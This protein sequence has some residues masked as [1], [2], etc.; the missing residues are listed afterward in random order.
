MK[1]INIV[2]SKKRICRLRA[3]FVRIVT[4]R[5]RDCGKACRDNYGEVTTARLIGPIGSGAENF[6][7]RCPRNLRDNGNYGVCY[8]P[9]E[10][11]ARDA[12]SRIASFDV[13]YVEE[14]LPRMICSSRNAR[15]D[16]MRDKIANYSVYSR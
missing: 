6:K 5:F 1:G 13:F 2:N 3:T 10:C 16:V 7:S 4:R 9:M 12:M 8:G 14:I 15:N 11:I